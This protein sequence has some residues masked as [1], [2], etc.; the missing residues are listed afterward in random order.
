MTPR[1]SIAM[2]VLD[3]E[4]TLPAAIASLRLQTFTDWELLIAD[5]G[6]TDASLAIAEEAA[7]ADG[8]ISVTAAP[9]R[10]GL[11]RSLNELVDG[12]AAPLLARMDADDVSYPQRLE[13]QV[14]FLDGHR[15]VDLVG[16]AMTV[17]R[18]GGA[19]IGKRT[20]PTEHGDICRRPASGFRLFHPTWLG[21]T[22]WFRRFGY[23]PA[24]VRC[25]D[26][27]LLYRAHRTSTFANIAEPLVGYREGR[28]G[29][30]RISAGR[31]N[32][33][34]RTTADLWR[35]GHR[36][37]AAGTMAEQIGKAGADAIA[38][39]TRLDHRVLRHRAGRISDAER[40]EWAAVWSSSSRY[41]DASSAASAS[42]EKRSVT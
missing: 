31:A 16:A 2:S 30:R 37:A 25:E 41:S 20:A 14:A 21:R 32:L 5:D 1:V 26:Q 27:D 15:D 6:S 18:D 42:S 10:R 22:D 24:A 17:F 13:R 29:F 40:A 33:T 12:A 8:R 19:A 4:R 39:G 9:E 11:A 34:R 7:A 35:R 28:L 23:D 38:L 36:L 3:A